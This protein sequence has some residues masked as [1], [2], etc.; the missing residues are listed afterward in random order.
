MEVPRAWRFCCV[1]GEEG[2]HDFENILYA[3]SFVRVLVQGDVF[4]FTPKP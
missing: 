3:V 2:F 4:I 1:G